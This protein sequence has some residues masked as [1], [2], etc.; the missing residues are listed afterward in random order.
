MSNEYGLLHIK[1]VKEIKC[2][3]SDKFLMEII[4][5]WQKTIKWI[6]LRLRFIFFVIA[7]D[8]SSWIGLL[9]WQS[10][11]LEWDTGHRSA[12]GHDFMWSSCIQMPSRKRW[13][14][15]SHKRTP[16]SLSNLHHGVC[17]E[18]RVTEPKVIMLSTICGAN[19]NVTI[20]KH[21]P[22]TSVLSDSAYEDGCK[23]SQGIHS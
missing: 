20:R 1:I 13:A 22:D 12:L 11:Q 4:L 19:L 21:S 8:T 3:M 9:I 15:S 14:T 6:W 18:Q 10:G 7:H 2:K 17:R 16:I 5:M 23:N